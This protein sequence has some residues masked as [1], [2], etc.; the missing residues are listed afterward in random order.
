MSP[1]TADTVS[2]LQSFKSV[3]AAFVR[4]TEDLLSRTRIQ[5]E[6][7]SGFLETKERV[8]QRYHRLREELDE[9]M[10]ESF[11]RGIRALTE[12]RGIVSLSDSEHDSLH[13]TIESADRDLQ[14]W[15]A[16]FQRKD[17]FRHGLEKQSRRQGVA[18]FVV[19]P[20]SF[21][22]LVALFVYF[23]LKFFLNR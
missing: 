18:A 8:I 2:N 21:V 19:I 4:Q 7:E 10:P 3:W 17:V 6:E 13:G 23:G 14:A 12:V 1:A 20:F 11:A 16:K 15:L 22:A 9:P 5:P